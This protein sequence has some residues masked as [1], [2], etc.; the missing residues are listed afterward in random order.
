MHPGPVTVIRASSLPAYTDCPRRAAARMFRAEIMAAGYQLAEPTQGVAA[1]IG[2]AVHAGAAVLLREK[3]QS[4][5]LPPVDDAL[6]AAVELLVERSAEGLSFDRDTPTR[7]DAEKQAIRMTRAYAQ[8]IAPEIEPLMVEDRLEAAYSA[9]IVL[10]GQADVI[11]REPGRV[12]DLK[13]GARRGH[14]KPQI[15]AY[16]L[17]ARTAG[18]QITEAAE[19]FI[20]R[21]PLKHDQPPGATY[22]HDLAAAESAAVAVLRHIEGDL[23]TFREGDPA[24]RLLP[25]DPWAFSANPN[26]KLCSA[27]W[28]PAFGTDFCREHHSED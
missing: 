20:Q 5:S 18:L 4:G 11:A 8:D 23:L 13:T 24:R 19:D 15:G 3:A 9:E 17:L 26:S 22:R 7:N 28:C 6:D 16:A 1:A 21:V 10:S 25:G 27:K 2:S 14:H 12:R